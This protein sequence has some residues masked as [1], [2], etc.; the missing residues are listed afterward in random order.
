MGNLA[1][2]NKV[3]HPPHG[4]KAQ[5]GQASLLSRLHDH[6]HT[7][8][9]AGLLWTSDQ[10]DA[11]TSDN[12]QQSQQNKHSC[13]RRDSNPQSEKASGRKTHA[14]GRAADVRYQIYQIL[15]FCVSTVVSFVSAIAKQPCMPEF[16]GVVNMKDVTVLFLHTNLL[17]SVCSVI[18][19]TGTVTEKSLILQGTK[20]LTEAWVPQILN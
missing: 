6:T 19:C 15:Q 11:E 9:S 2:L 20:C 16:R 8:H 12:T 3:S 17:D 4:A 18:L 14:L 7:P 13:P 5:S 10:P 1:T